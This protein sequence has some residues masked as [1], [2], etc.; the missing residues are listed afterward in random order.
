MADNEPLH[1]DLRAGQ[2]AL[3]RADWTGARAAFAQAAANAG[4][5]EA[6]DGLG[7]ALWWL[8]EVSDAH[9][10][11]ALA[12]RGYRDRGDI[13]RAARVAAW[14]ARE[15]IFLNGN[16]PAMMTWFARAEELA[17]HLKPGPARAWCAILRASLLAAPEE[18]AELAAATVAEARRSADGDLEAFALAFG[19]QAL[20]SLGRV[21]DG[22][23]HLDEAMTLA[24]GGDVVD[25]T[26]ISEVFCV[27]LSACEVAGDLA[28]SDVWCRTAMTFAAQYSCPFLAAYCR[29]AY[30]GL[31]TA[32]G[33]WQEAETALT[34]GIR[35]F[36]HGHR[37]LRVHAVIKL[38]DLRLSQGRL[39]EAAVLLA[40]LEDQTAAAVP[41]ARLA[42][43]QGDPCL[44]RATLE[45]TLPNSANYSLNHLP[46]LLAL[47][48]VLLALDDTAGV[49]R[50]L[51]HLEALAERAGSPLLTAQIVFTRGRAQLHSGDLAAAQAGFNAALGHLKFYEASLL[52]GQVRLRMAQTLQKS[53]PPGAVA[54]AKGALA[55]FERLGAEH[56]RAR[57]AALLR[58]LGV[59]DR[60]G[61]RLGQPLTRREREV[62]TLVARGLTNRDIAERLVISAKTVEHHV[63]HVLDKLSLR[64]R[65]ELMVLAAGGKLDALLG[66]EA[67][68]DREPD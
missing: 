61:P 4:T 37:G 17:A 32:L 11:R 24:T 20:V 65:A 40:G 21:G 10:Q 34:E 68:E 13:A 26:V 56:D 15:Q 31:L 36:E 57:A 62:A 43:S 2:A 18:M 48:E 23:A 28:R 54:W 3:A 58:Q 19:G 39:D 30:G 38:A 27:M 25:L 9:R 45:Q 29:T 55:T 63:G 53:D 35:A 14:L 8:N 1:D 16:Y 42:L 12:F 59:A 6:H 41:L 52:A 7:L 64:G 49:E 66:P 47:V 46:A 60:A 5:P 22:M 51:A 50:V 33:R 67:A 44:A